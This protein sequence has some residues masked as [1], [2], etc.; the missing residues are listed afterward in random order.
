[1]LAWWRFPATK[2][3]HRQQIS[4]CHRS[5]KS[6]L[7]DQ[8]K[9]DAFRSHKNAPNKS[10]VRPVTWIFACSKFDPGVLPMRGDE[11]VLI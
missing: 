3:F 2:I 6:P 9:N 5:K 1:M 10:W 4:I 8:Q 7:P 11:L